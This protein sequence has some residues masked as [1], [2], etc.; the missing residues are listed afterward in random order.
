M[1]DKKTPQKSISMKSVNRIA[2][3]LKVLSQNYSKVT[4]ISQKIGL[5]RLTVYRLLQAMKNTGM[6]IEDPVNHTYYL[7]QLFYRLSLDT[8]KEHQYIIGIARTRMENLASTCQET[9]NLH[10]VIGIERVRLL[11]VVGPQSLTYVGNQNT[12]SHIWVG[13]TGK[14][15]LAQMSD[16]EMQTI[17]DNI[18]PFAVTPFTITDKEVLKREVK[19]VRKLGY[20]TNIGEG[21]MGVASIAVPVYNYVSP[22]SLSIVA[23]IERFEPHIKDYLPEIKKTAREISDELTKVSGL[24]ISIEQR[25][26]V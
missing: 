10:I 6:V 4:D 17:I 15:L 12:V 9:V 19:K 11:T 22:A 25:A 21:A 8:S 7:G 5:S 3:L 24:C 20:A 13:A 2:G 26:K 14:I 1:R 16:A 23:P 18:T